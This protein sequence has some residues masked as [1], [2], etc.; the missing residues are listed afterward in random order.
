MDS[1]KLSGA[2]SSLIELVERLRS[3]A[4]CAWDAIQTDSSIRIYLLEEAYE[5]LEA[6]EKSSPPD[7]CMELGDLLFQI[8]FLAQ[9]A[10]ERKEFDFVEVIERIIE[11]MIRRHPHVFENERVGGAEDVALNWARI[12]MAERGAPGD[13]SALLRSVPVNLPALLRSHRL[14]ERA[15]KVDFDWANAD[16][17]W[18]KVR[19]ELE[20]LES[21]IVRKDRDE[22]AEELGDTLFALVNLA[23]HLG[24]NAENI[25][26]LANKRFL[27]RFER[28]EA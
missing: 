26:R 22:V 11:K 16:E 23:R 17:V 8:V 12:K 15:S 13:T 3:P 18:C 4:G 24:F 10:S 25:L 28:M 6:V 2:I 5:V 1:D 19:E 14:S 9:L 27:E 21:A 20:E 7:V